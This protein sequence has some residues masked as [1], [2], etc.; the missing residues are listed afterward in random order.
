M[1]PPGE[2]VRPAHIAITVGSPAAVEALGRSMQ[3]E[4]ATVVSGP[5]GNHRLPRPGACFILP[6]S[7]SAERGEKSAKS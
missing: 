3:A 6:A 2:R 4:G 7:G 1:Q 5:V